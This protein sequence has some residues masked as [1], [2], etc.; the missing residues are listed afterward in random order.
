MKNYNELKWYALI[1]DFNSDE[2]I[3]FNIFKNSNVH[4]LLDISLKNY[5]DFNT[6]KEELIKIFKYS[7]WSKSEYEIF[8]SGWWGKETHK[9]DVWYQLEPNIDLIA[10]YIIE[11]YNKR[12]RKKIIINGKEVK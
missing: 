3:R 6:F 1:N 2:I 4:R 12:K 8:V 10:R 11:T 7:F 5:T 9:I